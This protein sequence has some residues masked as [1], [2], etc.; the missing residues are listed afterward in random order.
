MSAMRSYHL[1]VIDGIVGV[2]HHLAEGEH[3]HVPVGGM[4]EASDDENNEPGQNGDGNVDGTGQ[5][6][7]LQEDDQNSQEGASVDRDPAT[8]MKTFSK[9]LVERLANLWRDH[10]ATLSFAIELQA[11]AANFLFYVVFFAIVFNLYEYFLFYFD[12]GVLFFQLF[13]TKPA[14]T[15]THPVWNVHQYFL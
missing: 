12:R 3:H 11:Q 4:A 2:F 5:Q 9:T 8:H 7:Q 15:T 13:I 6:A 14:R 10:R 1:H